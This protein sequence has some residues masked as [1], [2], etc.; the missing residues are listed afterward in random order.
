MDTLALTSD[1]DLYV[2]LSGN[3]ATATGRAA[4]AQDV[5]S[6]VRVFLG[7]LWYDTAQGVPYFQ[8]SIQERSILGKPAS[9]QFMKAKFVGA[10]LTV[11]GVASIRCFLMGPGP[12]RV[13]GG[14]LQITDVDG[15]TAVLQTPQIG[16]LPFY[17]SAVDPFD[18]LGC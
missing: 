8:R 7:E 2:D 3:I 5:A 15:I 17:V 12:N 9:Y 6:A 16:V 14:Q 1:W 10:G 18:P 13:I 4:L 11:T